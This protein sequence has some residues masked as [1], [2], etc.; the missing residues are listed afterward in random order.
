MR[1]AAFQVRE[2]SDYRHCWW[3]RW[4]GGLAKEKM[5]NPKETGF[6]KGDGRERGLVEGFVHLE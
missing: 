1:E 4:T 5:F 6:K 3:T 2:R